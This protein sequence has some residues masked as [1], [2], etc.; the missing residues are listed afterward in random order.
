LISVAWQAERGWRWKWEGEGE[1]ERA[2]RGARTYLLLSGKHLG[3]AISIFPTADNK[4]MNMS[5]A[6]VKYGL[7][8]GFGFGFGTGIACAL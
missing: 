2:G 4:K 7:G 5:T 3:Q 6:H 8:F 1:G